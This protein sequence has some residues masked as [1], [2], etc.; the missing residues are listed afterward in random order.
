MQRPRI[1]AGFVQ[2]TLAGLEPAS[3]RRVRARLA[4]ET[5]EVLERSS[6]LAWLPIE[7][8]VELTHAIYLEFGAGRA[9]ELFRRNLSAALDSPILRSF[10]QGA[11][12]LFGAS[13]ERVFGWAP[14]AYAQIYRDS[15]AMRFR[16]EGP[17]VARL[18]LSE[19][20][21]VIA[22]SRNYLDGVAGSIAAGFDLMG[23]KGEV[24]IERFDPVRRSACFRLEWEDDEPTESLP[25]PAGA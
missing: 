3:A 11:L 23:V 19:L 13:P 8:D 22:S 9:H 7:I 12:R 14:R 25:A 18:E 10:A 5:L 15:G 16:A 17:G 20:P 2:G 21:P 1:L 4:A 24:A 6:R